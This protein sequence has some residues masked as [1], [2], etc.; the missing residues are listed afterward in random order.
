VT[1]QVKYENALARS[2]DLAPTPGLIVNGHRQVGWGRYTILEN[3]VKREIERA[4]KIAD[5]GVPVSRVA[6]EAT[7]QSGPNGEKVAAALFA[8]PK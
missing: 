2:I 8:I 6:Y 5:S 4:K 3:L 7:R 1:A